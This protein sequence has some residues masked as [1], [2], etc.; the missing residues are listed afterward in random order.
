MK[1]EK[2]ILHKA[3]SRQIEELRVKKTEK[4]KKAQTSIYQS[5][6]R[7]RNKFQEK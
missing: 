2:N 7:Q 1:K 6:Q 5:S 3:H 4:W